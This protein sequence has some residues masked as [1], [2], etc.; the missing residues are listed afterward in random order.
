MQSPHQHR[1]REQQLCALLRGE[2]GHAGERLARDRGVERAVREVQRAKA[3]RER[4]QLRRRERGDQVQRARRDGLRR[5]SFVNDSS[6]SS[7]TSIK[8]KQMS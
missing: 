2:R 4:H 6:S 5:N 7:S 3:G 8:D 1:I